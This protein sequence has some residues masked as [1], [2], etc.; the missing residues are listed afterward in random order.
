MRRFNADDTRR[1]RVANQG[2]GDTRA[3]NVLDA[4]S[5][6]VALQ[7]QD[8]RANRLAVRVRTTGLTAKDVD[9]ACRDRTVV[10]T[11]A[12]RG[13][14]HMLAAADFWWMNGV[15][16]PYFAARGAPRRR[17]LGLD[18]DL[19]ERAAGALEKHLREPL[20]RRELVDRLDLPIDPDSQAPAHLLAWAAN[21]GLVCRGPENDH[22]EP[23]YV[24]AQD[25]VG[26]R[27]DIDLPAATATLARRYLAGYGPA[28]AEDLAAWSGLPITRARAAL[29]SVADEVT[30]VDLDGVTG[31]VVGEVDTAPAPARLLGHFDAYLL[32]YRGRDLAVP[33]DLRPRVQTGGG[34]VMPTVLV[35]GRAV[36]TWRTTA[37]G[38]AL[39]VEI[40]TGS[41]ISGEIGNEVADLGR[42]LGRRAELATPTG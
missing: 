29:A 12:M 16:G 34:F 39:T 11:W 20:G 28:T 6:A 18:D 42:F 8:H 22:G 17:Q 10:R 26:A 25:W 1:A 41:R 2:L 36:G 38:D 15:L 23:T 30:A 21:V 13:T 40:D 5:Q 9:A 31:Y 32:G 37:E 33:A 35:D 27:P 19:L 7:G 4:V 24:L 3:T 14:L